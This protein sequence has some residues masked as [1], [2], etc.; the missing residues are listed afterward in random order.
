MSEDPYEAVSFTHG[1]ETPDNISM[2]SESMV[3]DDMLPPSQFSTGSRKR[4]RDH[5]SLEDQQH[6]L[7]ADS[8]LDYFMLL[9]SDDRFPQPP[10]PPPT[11]NLNRSIDEKGHTALHWAAAMGDLDV[12]R[13]LVRRGADIASLSINRETPLMRAV[14]FTNNFDKN[15]MPRMARTLINTVNLTDWFGS[16]VFHH[17]AATTSSKNKYYSARYYLD[18]IISIMTET[19]PPDDITKILNQQDNNGDTAIMIAARNGARKCVRS[20]LGRNVNVDIPNHLNETADALILELNR[21]RQARGQRQASSSPFA[22]DTHVNGNGVAVPQPLAA[23]RYHSQTAN[24]LMSTIAPT[25]AEQCEQLAA[26]YEAELDDKEQDSAETERVLHMRQ[27]EVDSVQRQ[28]ADLESLERDGLDDH[29][30]E[31]DGELAGLIAESEALHELEQRYDL[32]QLLKL[33]EAKGQQAPQPTANGADAMQEKLKLATAL[34]KAQSER[35]ALIPD[36]VQALSV[37]GMGERQAE[38]KRLIT[39]ALGVREQDVEGMLP[40][41]L[42]ELEDARERERLD[43][44][45]S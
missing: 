43:A 7:W 35:K 33:E 21:R 11:V 37:A 16:T 36:I 32:Q 20:L 24:T 15:T 10:D 14:M 28:L 12:V 27:A 31:L 26:A 4:K 42:A 2:V 34:Y 40:D 29:E 23:Q 17:I 39:G 8:L 44:S 25:F 9:E 3:E 30:A 5:L 38:Y 18:S 19:W 45:S 41:I 22:P 6:Q 1:A 13:D